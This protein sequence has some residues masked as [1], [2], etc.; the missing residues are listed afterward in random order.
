LL[1]VV[2]LKNLQVIQFSHFLVKEFLMSSRFTEKCDTISD[3]YHISMTPAHALV[4]QACLGVLL[5]LDANVTRDILAKFRLA[6]YAVEHWFEHA[7]FEGVSQ[8]AGE[9]VKWL[10]DTR[11]P[12]FMIWLWIC[13]P[14]VSSWN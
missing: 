8:N 9:G 7:H 13:D 10:F 14:T 6:S 5:H 3:R 4:A 11:K 12:H 1:S 2:T